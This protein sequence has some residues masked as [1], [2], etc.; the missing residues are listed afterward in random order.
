VVPGRRTRN[1]GRRYGASRPH[2]TRGRIAGRAQANRY[3][4]AG[5]PGASGCAP[6]PLPVGDI[7]GSAGP[8]D[9]AR[10]HGQCCHSVYLKRHGTSFH[11]CGRKGNP[12]ILFCNALTE[13]STR[14]I[15]RAERA[16]GSCEGGPASRGEDTPE[17]REEMPYRP[18]PVIG[19]ERGCRFGGGESAVAP[20]VALLA[21]TPKG[22]D[23]V[24]EDC[25]DPHYDPR[26]DRSAT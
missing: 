7:P 3:A 6:G 5:S 24:L 15:T 21:R 14:G 22:S 17:R 8:S 19:P 13:T 25:D 26:P 16:A 23:E 10:H 11:R 2:G 18:A 9:L 20:R 4:C 12:S 1:A